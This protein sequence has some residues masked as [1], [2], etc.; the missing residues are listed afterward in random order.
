[1][2]TRK[3]IDAGAEYL[4]AEEVRT[5]GEIGGH[6][7]IDVVDK[8]LPKNALD[9]EA[10]MNE[11]VTIVVNPPT[12]ADDPTLIQVGVNGVNQF[13]RRGDA[14]D[15]KRKYVEVLARSKRTDFAQTLDERLGEQGFNSLRSMHSL[16][17]PFS[18]L[19]DPNPNGG[20]WLTAIL[21]EAR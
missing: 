16:R 9:M 11:V 12:D 5:V 21:R 2:A 13:I 8:P 14:V 17:Y 7:G 19:R 4:G 10:F 15:V 1:M 6:A 3:Q 20:A 18:M